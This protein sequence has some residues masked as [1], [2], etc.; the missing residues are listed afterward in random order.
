MSKAYTNHFKERTGS[1]SGEEPV[2]LLEILHA[3]LEVPI[4][5]VRDVENIISNG[6]TYLAFAFEIALPDDIEN[7]M[8]RAPVRM[9]NVGGELTAWLEASQGGRGSQ[10]RIM[11]VM[12]DTP[13][14]LEFDATLDL[15]NVRR[16]G[17][18]VYG[19]LGYEDTLSLPALA[20]TQ[21]PDV[22][23]GIF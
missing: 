7:Q 15:L 14:V 17:A 20:V 6:E 2:Y 19:E 13:D 21:R 5:V 18:F 22:Q 23:P 1:T 9:D 10:V 11:Q 3:Q 8:P 12:R 4:R 16:D